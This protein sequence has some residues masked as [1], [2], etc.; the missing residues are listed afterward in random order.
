MKEWRERVIA[1]PLLRAVAGTYAAKERRVKRSAAIGSL[2]AFAAVTTSRRSIASAAPDKI[3]VLR[4]IVE[5][6]M[7]PEYALE[8]GLFEKYGLD[9][10]VEISASGQAATAAVLGGAAQIA[11]SNT[12]GLVVAH[13]KSIPVS[14]FAPGAAYLP[15]PPTV[16]V[17]VAKNSPYHAAADLQGKTV[18]VEGLHDLGTLAVMAWMQKNGVDPKTVRFVEMSAAVLGAAVARGT[19]D[20]AEIFTPF[21]EQS[22]DTCRSLTMPYAAIADHFLINGW[23]AHNDWLSANRDVAARFTRAVIEA[24]VWANRERDKSGKMLA[25]FSKIDPATIARMT[26]ATYASRLDVALVQP[27]VNIAAQFELIPAAYPASQLIAPVTG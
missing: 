4:A 14:L 16:G 17:M 5:S 2:V 8:L 12:L 18:G 3:R 20:A 6:T 21:Y 11:S 22:L 9:V 19:I 23:F 1:A 24:Q 7:G 25:A 10:T 26:R 13:A 27:I 15:G